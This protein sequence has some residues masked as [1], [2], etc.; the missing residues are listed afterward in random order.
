MEI[1]NAP[2]FDN[3]T[4]PERGTRHS[5]NPFCEAI[6]TFICGCQNVDREMLAKIKYTIKLGV[7]IDVI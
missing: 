5:C 1:L 7:P 3:N 2:L 4:K 6:K